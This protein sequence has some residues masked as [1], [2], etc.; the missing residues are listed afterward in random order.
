M[1]EM[2]SMTTRA[3]KDTSSYGLAIFSVPDWH[4]ASLCAG[5]KEFGG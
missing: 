4:Y 5:Q 1:A 3:T 2:S